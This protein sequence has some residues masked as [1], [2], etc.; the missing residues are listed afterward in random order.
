MTAQREFADSVHRHME[1]F[2]L[3]ELMVAM[4]I[5]LILMAGVIQIFTGTKNTFITQEGTSRLQEN[6]RFA[7]S[8]LSEDISAAGYLG[9]LDSEA[10]ISQI[11]NDLTNKAAGSAYDFSA[12]IFGTDN[13][14]VNGSDTISIRRGGSGGGIRL[15]GPMQT[16][17]SDILLD[18]TSVAYSSL[19]LF[20]I[21]VVGDCGTA[22]VFM[23]TNMPSVSRGSIQHDPGVTANSGPNSG[24]S[25]IAGDLENIF[26]ADTSSVASATK[27]ETSTYQLCNSTSGIGTSLFLNSNN[28]VD[29]TIANEL[30]E[31]V[32][33]MQFLYGIDDANTSPGVEQ[34]LR[35]DQILTAQW[36]SIASVRMTLRFDTVSYVPGGMIKQDFTT[37][38][39]LRNRG[40]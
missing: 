35:A 8:G 36:N 1:G 29:A 30:V 17:I 25:N 3:V 37:T 34:Y 33:S 16:S 6:V 31:G 26:G 20:D 13:T 39:R 5:S 27:V 2:S 7:L 4:L 11:R 12:P 10:P 9:C 28:C 19:K 38:V 21:L 40:G 18:D 14:G 15:I 24:Q 32:Q 22:S 23:I